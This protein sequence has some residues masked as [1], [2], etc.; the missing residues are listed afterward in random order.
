[1][2]LASGLTRQSLKAK[3]SSEILKQP[4]PDKLLSKKGKKSR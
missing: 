1:M 3:V 2:E 4:R